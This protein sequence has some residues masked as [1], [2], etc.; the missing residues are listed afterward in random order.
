MATL[1]LR[2]FFYCA[3]LNG[4]PA[5][6]AGFC[7]RPHNETAAIP[8]FIQYQ[9]GKRGQKVVNLHIRRLI[10]SIFKGLFLSD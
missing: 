4:N 7:G 5:W 9:K 8:F 10:L 2:Q 1:H 6:A 3:G